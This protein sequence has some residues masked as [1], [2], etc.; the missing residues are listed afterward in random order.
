M[1]LSGPKKHLED[2]NKFL[3]EKYLEIF[4]FSFEIYLV[5]VVILLFYIE[6]LLIENLYELVFFELNL[7]FYLLNHFGLDVFLF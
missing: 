7:S 5:E 6:F 1:F 2:Q 3:F 4:L